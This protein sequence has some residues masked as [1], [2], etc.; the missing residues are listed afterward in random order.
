MLP[1]NRL[2]C[3]GL[4]RVFKTCYYLT[5]LSGWNPRILRKGPGASGAPTWLEF[6]INCTLALPSA[7]G[8]PSV[9][10]RPWHVGAPGLSR[11]S[12]TLKKAVKTIENYWWYSGPCLGATVG[13]VWNS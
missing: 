7:P 1:P 6:A 2:K 8:P 3:K 11:P 9:R 12:P 13:Q 5:V 4:G 10:T